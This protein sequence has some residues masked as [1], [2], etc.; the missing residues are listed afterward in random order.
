MAAL[1]FSVAHAQN[2]DLSQP[3]P[4]DSTVTKGKLPNGLTYYIKPNAK[5]AQ[6]VE[7][8]LVE[9]AGSLLENDNQQGLAHFM[10]HMNFNG[11]KHYPKNQLVDYLQ[12]IG[13]QFGADLN[14]NTGFDRTYFMLPIPTDK[15]GNLENGFQIVADWAGGALITTDEVNDERHVILE[16][17]R[18][19]NKNA[20]MRMLYKILPELTNHSRYASRFPSGLDSIVLHASPDRIREFYHDWY[21]PD[22]QAVIVVGDITVDKAKS[23]I[24]KYFGALKNPAHERTRTVYEVA[25][26]TQKKALIVTDSEETNYSFSLYYP[27]HKAKVEKTLGDYREDLIKN[28]MIQGLNRKLRDLAQS[29]NPPYASASGYFTEGFSLHD[30]Q[31]ALDIVPVDDYKKA[32]NAAV[33]VLLQVEKY[34]LTDADIET[35]KR[36]YL[37]GYEKAF[38]E[39][40][41]T[42][43][44]AYTDELADNF[45]TNEPIPGIVNEYN[46]VK[47]LLP[48][49][50]AKDVNAAAQKW[51]LE[52]QNYF[53]LISA[54]STGKIQLPDESGLLSMVDAAF[55]QD[56][57][58][59]ETTGTATSLLQMQP[60]A[61]KIVSETKDA[62]LGTT[63]YT[64]SNGVKVTIKPT[65][66]KNDEIVLTGGRLGGTGQFSVADKANVTFLG[67]VIGA[68]GYGQFT[69]SELN[70][71]L[72]GKNA[73]VGV[74][75]GA[76]TNGISGS[77]SVKDLPTLLELMY[78]KL[79]SPRKDTSLYKGYM[80]KLKSQLQFLKANPQ[81]AFIDSSNKVMYGNNPLTPISVPTENDLNSI[82]PDRILDIYKDQ[83]GYADG[84]HLFFVG[85]VNADSLKPLLEKYVASL[86]VKGV[87][88]AYKDNGLRMVPGDKTFKFYKGT[89]QKSLILDYYHGD[90][91]Y[92]EDADLKLDMLTQAMTIKVLDTI[93]EKM[94]AIYSG[95]VYASVA[96]LPYGHYSIIAQLP[97]GPENVDK[98]LAEYAKE[99]AGYKKNG[100][101]ATDLEKV[102]K[103]MLE[104]YKESMKQNG[105]W[106]GELQDIYMFGH[107]KDYLL[108]FDKKI[109]AVTSE[110]LK[111]FADEVLNNNNNYKAISYPEQASGK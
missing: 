21:R 86:P 89:D 26:Y 9:N 53:A 7:L 67:S 106:A 105:Y 95:G 4:I 76:A 38:N 37:A 44:A 104:K 83:F 99:V 73:K 88:P 74:G 69:P 47:E 82:N 107:S 71:F 5:P 24:E 34:G 70:D 13:V 36:S 61:G 65:D 97:C 96:E 16:E 1:Q 49:I 57:K 30:E 77:S 56:V 2:L 27:T 42:E 35:S 72:S 80:T 101:S 75:F 51:L 45:M 19:R 46:Y 94:Q 39:R 10:E 102:K 50:T 23:L 43:S 15:P 6:K 87:K 8:R 111:K 79:T 32:I 54:P 81:Y 98:I 14:A 40:N 11:L 85:N 93:R 41:T 20:N 91:K 110:D 100:V 92:S 25:P 63:T 109:N 66:F 84:L 3:L 108:N 55:K 90:I 22:L 52:N 12:K 59:A 31:F 58:P 48:T 29:A 28:I 103:A 18:M 78:L 33:G 17:L 60:V 68:M 62:D 64:L